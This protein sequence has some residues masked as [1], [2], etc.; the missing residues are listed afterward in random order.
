MIRNSWEIQAGLELQSRVVLCVLEVE[1]E[2]KQKKKRSDFRRKDRA[3]DK[4]T[5]PY[6]N[7]VNPAAGYG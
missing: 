1:L 7:S 6:R 5:A 4:L 2:K 3:G